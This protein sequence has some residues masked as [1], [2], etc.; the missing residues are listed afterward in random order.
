VENRHIS[1]TLIA[2]VPATSGRTPIG[3]DYC[4]LPDFDVGI[5]GFASLSFDHF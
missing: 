1:W 3:G 2:Q 5:R 4:V